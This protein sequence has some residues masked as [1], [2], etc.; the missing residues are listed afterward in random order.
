MPYAAW[1]HSSDGRTAAEKGY[2]HMPKRTSSVAVATTL[3]ALAIASAVV[4]PAA[5]ARDVS[6]HTVWDRVASCES[7]NSWHIDTGNGFYG[8]L[9]FTN[10]TWH[11]FGGGRYAGRADHASRNEQIEVARRVLNAQGRDAWPV[12]GPRAG[13]TRSSGHATGSRVPEHAAPPPGQRSSGHPARRPAPWQAPCPP[14]PPC[15]QDLHGQ[16]R[17]HFEQ[18]RPHASHLG[19]LEVAVPL[20]PV[21]SA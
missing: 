1:S 13:L 16:V 8:G 3:G 17:R 6:H 11:A 10:Q 4:A 7:S 21:S 12:C 5:D 2:I 15:P 20:E 9:Q 14:C 18:D 19:R